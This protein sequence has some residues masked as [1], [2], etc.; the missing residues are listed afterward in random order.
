MNT[1]KTRRVFQLACASS[2][3]CLA[4]FGGAAH[5]AGDVD[6][7]GF[8]DLKQMIAKMPEM[9]DRN[10]DGMISRKEYLD[11]QGKMF[12]MASKKGMMTMDQFKSF[13]MEFRTFGQLRRRIFRRAIAR[14]GQSRA[15]RRSPLEKCL[16]LRAPDARFIDEAGQVVEVD[17]TGDARLIGD[18]ATARRDFVLAVTPVVTHAQSAGQQ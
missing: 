18:V 5:A 14:G 10:K 11:M 16:E 2:L 7:H 1:R 3:F 12:D 8:N 17:P 13:M 15:T 9:T 6:P 4:L